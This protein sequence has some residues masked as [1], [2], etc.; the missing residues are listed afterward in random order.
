[1]NRMINNTI[2]CGSLWHSVHMS[3]DNVNAFIDVDI[4]RQIVADS[5]RHNTISIQNT[6][7]IP[8]WNHTREIISEMNTKQC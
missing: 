7:E 8:V 4:I 6:V 5:V 3:L 2:V 1:M